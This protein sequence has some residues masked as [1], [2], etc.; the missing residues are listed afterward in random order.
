M[1]SLTLTR[2]TSNHFYDM[3]VATNQKYQEIIEKNQLQPILKRLTSQNIEL[4]SKK[5][6]Y[7]QCDRDFKH[8]D[9]V[10]RIIKILS[11]YDRLNIASNE[12][13]QDKFI[14]LMS[15]YKQ[16]V[17]DFIHLH[18]NHCDELKHMNEELIECKITTC[19][20]TSR[21]HGSVATINDNK[22]RFYVQLM[23]TLHFYLYHCYDAGLR[24][25]QRDY[26]GNQYEN[27]D[28]ITD[29]PY[30]DAT[31][32]K[33]NKYVSDRKRITKSF[34][35][36]STNNRFTVQLNSQEKNTTTP[37]DEMYLYLQKMNIV[38]HCIQ[39]LKQFIETE[40]Y[41]TDCIQYEF[42][43]ENDIQRG[44]ISTIIDNNLCDRHIYEF[45][46]SMKISASSFSIGL[47]FYY[48]KYYESITQMPDDEQYIEN[49][50]DHSGY[51]ICDLYIKPKYSTF[52]EEISN[53]KHINFQ[54]YKD[55]VVLKVNKYQQS[56]FTKRIQAA[57]I[58]VPEHYEIEYKSLLQFDHI[59]S[60]VL[61]TDYTTLSTDFSSTFR[62]CRPFETLD[63]I[64]KRNSVYYWF[65]RRL[66]ECVEMYGHCQWSVPISFT[67]SQPKIEKKSALSGPFYCGMNTAMHMPSFN[68][69]LCSPTSTSIQLA[70][71]VQFSGCHGMVIQL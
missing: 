10:T 29:D 1:R 46:Q 18:N 41:D 71:A 6:D 60:I 27:D 28:E 38:S 25:R 33:I 36:F 9:A 32:S 2:E 68:I 11:Y 26:I 57:K 7:N 14:K 19:D 3:R 53:Y 42:Q 34:E 37:I 17:D 13:Y 52:G 62:K 40:E 16:F 65:S 47:R 67:E 70:V 8:C 5:Y 63:S 24:V 15:I 31:F 64:K 43:H 44:N 50:N 4:F 49:I 30:F 59:L 45:V 51:D 54:H 69:R 58:F 20:F 35:R 12:Q 22:L 56:T 55:V 39:K 61:Y 23:D 21:H 66:R 48:W